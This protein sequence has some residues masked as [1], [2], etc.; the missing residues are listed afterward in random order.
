GTVVPTSVT[1]TPA[2]WNTPKVITV[3]GQDDDVVDGNTAYS[4]ITSAA[5]STDQSYNGREVADVAMINLDNDSAGILVQPTTGQTTEAGGTATFTIRLTSRPTADVTIGLSSSDTS[6]GTVSPASITITPATWNTPRQVTATGQDDQEADGNVAYTIITAP[7]VSGD[8]L[9]QGRNAPD[10]SLTNVDN[11]SVGITVQPTIGQ[12]TEAGGTATFT[13]VLNSRPTAN[14]TIG[15]SSSDTTEGVVSPTQTTFTP[16]NFS[17]PQSVTVTGQDDQ[18]ADGLMPYSIVTAPAVSTDTNY[19]NWNAPDVAM[20]NVDNDA[21]GIIV[22]DAANLQTTEAGGTAQF[23]IRLASEPTANVTIA[24]SSS[25]TTEGIVSPASVTFTPSDWNQFKA[26]TVTGQDDQVDDGD[27]TYRVLIAPAQ[28]ADPSYQNR[29]ADDPSVV[30]R[31]NDDAGITVNATSPLTVSEAG[32]TAPISVV[33]RSQP[34]ATVTVTFTSSDTTEGTLAPASLEFTAANWNTPRSVTLTGVNDD[35]VDGDVAFTISA[36][37]ASADPRY[38]ALTINPLPAVNLDNDQPGI[39]VSPVADLATSEAGTTASFQVFLNTQ[40]QANVS[41]NLASSDT[42]EGTISP[43]SLLFT[44]SNWSTPQ[45]VT[46]TGVDDA[47]ADGDVAYTIVTSPASSSDANYNNFK[48]LDV[49]VINLDNDVASVDVTAPADPRTTE[50]GGTTQLTVVLR[51]QPTANVTVDVS[52]SDTSEGTVSPALLT[53]TPTNWNQPQTVVVT[54]VDDLVTDG[55]VGF[56]VVLVASSQDANYDGL[57]PRTVRVTNDDNDFPGINVHPTSGLETSEAGATT[58]FQ[59]VLNTQPTSSVSIGLSSSNTAEGTVSTNQAVFTTTNW[60]VPQTVTIT[61]VDDP[62]VDGD[63]QY[64]IDIHPAVSDDASYNGIDAADVTVVNRDND[65][66]SVVITPTTGLTTSESGQTATFTVRL[67]SQP[68]SNVTIGLSS[69]DTTEGAVAPASLVFTPADWNV[70]QTVTVTGV[71]DHVD[72]GDVTFTIITTAA[73]SADPIY[74]N[75]PVADVN[76]VNINDDVADIVVSGAAG[77]VTEETGTQA[78]F[79]IVLATEPA[80]DV[81]I[82]V[83]SSDP[84][85]GA[86]APDLVTFTPANWN[87]PRTITVTGVDDQAADGN[88]VYQIILGPVSSSDAKYA[89]IELDAIDVTNVDDDMPGITV[90]PPSGLETTEGGPPVTLQVKLNTQPTADVTLA[91][92]S[93]NENEAVL[94]TETLTFTSSNWSTPQTVSVQGVEDSIIDGNI[95]YALSVT[96]TASEDAGYAALQPVAIAAINRDNDVAGITVTGAESLTTSEAGGTDTFSISLTAQPAADVVVSLSSTDDSEGLPVTTQLTFTPDTWNVPREVTI[97]GVDDQVVDGNVGYGF[98]VTLSSD[99]T[100]FGNV[101]PITIPAINQDDD[102]AQLILSTPSASVIEQT[103]VTNPRVTVLVQLVGEVAGG[104]TVSYATS[105]G[106][107][108]DTDYVHAEGSLAFSGT[109]EEV[110]SFEIEVVADDMLEP[111][112]TFLVTLL[113]LGNISPSAAQRIELTG[114]PLTFTILDDDEPT[115]SFSSVSQPEG[116]GPTPTVFRFDVVLSNPVQGGLRIHYTTS[117][118]TATLADNDYI[119]NDGVLEFAGTR[120]EVHSIDVLV[121][122]DSAVELDETFV[123]TLEEIIFLDPVLAETIVAE[124]GSQFGTILNDDTASISFV[125]GSSTAIES[126]GSHAIDVR[127]SVTSGGTL[128]QDATV[129]LDIL[130]GN[131]ATV[132]DDFSFDSS[133]ITFPAGSRDGDT[134]SVRLSLVTNDAME[135]DEQATFQLTLIAGGMEGAVALASPADHHFVLTEDPMTASISGMVWFDS[136]NNGVRDAGESGVPGVLVR[137]TG[138]DLRG[139]A[140]DITVM[141]DDSGAYRFAR[142]PGGTYTIQQQ[143][144]H[145]FVDGIDVRGTVNGVAAGDVA[146]DRFFN[147]ALPITGQG[148]GY[149]FGERSLAQTRL[150]PRLFLASTPDW[151]A[152]VRQIVAAAEEKAGNTALA[153]AIRAGEYPEVRRHGTRVEVTGTSQS[154]QVTFTPAGSSQAPGSTH[155]AVTVNGI[156]WTFAAN[157]VNAFSLKG[158]SGTDQLVLNDSPASDLLTASHDL[159][160]LSSED[161]LVDAMEFELIRAV[162]SSGGTDEAVVDEPT[163]GLELVGPW[164]ET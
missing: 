142:L 44:P 11:D 103:D 31:D 89:A 40:P 28:S 65:V 57:A 43:T 118:G 141:T 15:L 138:V 34:T 47:V 108:S 93:S 151:T 84:G 164:D 67:T 137:L 50:W 92:T 111:D 128:T 51:S 6:E 53:F 78:S 48:P 33:L 37:I 86:A 49:S 117:D 9:Y 131:T 41:I 105:H 36:Q 127:L 147:I 72:D 3:T 145:A 56:D 22:A 81:S 125:T 154:D 96:V 109:N 132:P 133:T 7:A 126:T 129:R 1:F 95:A 112:E 13:I 139:P 153:G 106:T 27:V 122:A 149:D 123:V 29:D 59:I 19:S 16:S 60:N 35:I 68:A 113:G 76:V 5:I 115:I 110:H 83:S 97:R 100:H 39:T 4:I 2:N 42:T 124:G 75:L 61:G 163:Y 159:A 58:T 17:T 158:S 94:L 26:V 143:Q 116:T 63:Q 32:T 107:A 157:Q 25:D 156:P 146:N 101:D 79:T 24:L 114:S 98:T 69:S 18:I 82:P 144:P 52:S 120:G 54:G 136:N 135:E 150:S 38:S 155:H 45:V 104:F 162:S 66:A 130:P 77:L 91:I 74:N 121:I 80:G 119:D 152:S 102:S 30:N 85:E 55:D 90:I 161:F 160:I 148:V 70:N 64:M 140:V 71:D 73:A 14:V 21:A 8:P 134:R 62:R 88:Q 12:T 87:V 46:I 10:V 23:T 20:T 99:D